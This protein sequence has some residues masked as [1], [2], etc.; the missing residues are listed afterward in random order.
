M[1]RSKVSFAVCLLVW[2]ASAAAQ[3]TVELPLE[4]WYRPGRYM[5]VRITVADTAGAAEEQL[6]LRGAG[7]VS[8][9]LYVQGG[10]GAAMV[11]WMAA[12][13][14]G[15]AAYRWRGRDVPLELPL[16]VM[17]SQQRLVGLTGTDRAAARGLFPHHNVLTVWLDPARPIAPPAAAWT[18]LDG[19]LLDSAAAGRID[20]PALQT[21]LSAGTTVAVAAD[22]PPHR[23]WPWQR[24]GGLWVLRP[25][26]AGPADGMANPAVYTPVGSWSPG[27]PASLRR[28]AA[29][30]GLIVCLLV[31]G[32][33]LLRPRAAV[34]ALLGVSAAATAGI[35][36]WAARQTPVVWQGGDVLVYPDGPA[37]RDT[38]R[39]Y[40][41]L[42][43]TRAGVEWESL[44]WPIFAGRLQA[45]M[46]DMLLRCDESGRPIEFTFD[47]KSGMKLAMLTRTVAP[48][49]AAEQAQTPV[50]S[51]LHPLV[52]G[53][54]LRPG[55]AVAGQ[56]PA[57]WPAW[58]TIVCTTRPSSP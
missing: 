53:I 28:R 45:R 15:E 11:P 38:W 10:R 46:A 34:L 44:T 21:L 13:R 35:G 17:D 24:E 55:L 36:L 52:R 31:L 39:Y 33:C 26:I 50:T 48:A 3:V 4:G 49:A 58:P 30:L 18:V 7:A 27:A 6:I 20:E 12:E 51:P 37:Q 8:T 5:P 40:A 23:G 32:A 57:A 1:I 42:R 29:F 19:V 22:N 54:Y 43:P 56:R 25:Q 2:A 41:A 47:V 14:L 9:S 16:R